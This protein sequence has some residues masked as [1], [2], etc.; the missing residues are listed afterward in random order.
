MDIN[1]Y[2][3]QFEGQDTEPIDRLDDIAQ[4]SLEAEM[5]LDR[6]RGGSG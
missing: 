4:A 1:A 2:L 6:R 3:D 5:E